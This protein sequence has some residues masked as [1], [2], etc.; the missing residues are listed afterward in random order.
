MTNNDIKTQ[1]TEQV[2]FILLNTES[3]TPSYRLLIQTPKPLPGHDKG[4]NSVQYDESKIKE[5]VKQLKGKFVIDETQSGHNKRKPPENRGHKF[6][7][8]TKTGYCPD[9]GAYAD[10]KVFDKNYHDLLKETYNSIQDGLPI[11]EGPS[12]ETDVTRAHT[13]KSN[14]LFIDDW[15]YTGIVWDNN[16]RDN[17]GVCKILNSIE[18]VLEDNNMTEDMIKLSKD[19]YDELLQFKQDKAKL[20]SDLDALGAKYKDGEKQFLDGKKLYDEIKEKADTLEEEIKPYKDWLASQKTSLVDGIL[21][22]IPEAEREEKKTELDGMTIDQLKI[23]NSLPGHSGGQGTAEGNGATNANGNT[24][25]DDDFDP[26]NDPTM[27]ALEK[28]GYF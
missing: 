4:Y 16:P 22:S 23:M 3:K 18:E 8:I 21:N 6:A 26:E 25:N 12:T 24:G 20:E 13:D 14:N 17:V 11:H 7:K 28:M 15:D 5:K 10:V 19:E 27:K 1:M 9:Y 2:P